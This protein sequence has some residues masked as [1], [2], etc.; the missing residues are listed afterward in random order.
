MRVALRGLAAAFKQS[1]QGECHSTPLEDH[2]LG[3]CGIAIGHEDQPP[4]H[5]DPSHYRSQH[6]P[7]RT[8]HLRAAPGAGAPRTRLPVPEEVLRGDA[9]GLVSQNLVEHVLEHGRA[10]GHARNRPDDVGDRSTLDALPGEDLMR[11]QDRPERGELLGDDERVDRLGDLDEPHFAA[12][13]HQRKTLT[14]ASTHEPGGQLGEPA[15]ELDH[16]SGGIRTREAHDVVAQL[17]IARG[18]RHPG[19][20]DQLAALKQPGDVWKLADVDPPHRPVQVRTTCQNLRLPVAQGRQVKDPG[21]RG[22]HSLDGLVHVTHTGL[23]AVNLHSRR[24]ADIVQ[25]ARD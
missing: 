19:R 3:R 6:P 24:T 2:A 16:H 5:V 4:P 8:R 18:Q 20:E 7:L 23:L 11:L 10:V 12:Q 17:V 9:Q 22:Q 21:N 1:V 13:R 14:L 15:A 25:S